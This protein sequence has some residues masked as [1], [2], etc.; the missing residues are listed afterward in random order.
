MF[1]D[2]KFEEIGKIIPGK[3]VIKFPGTDINML[4][5]ES[6]V[7]INEAGSTG[8]ASLGIRDVE[9]SEAG[10]VEGL[11]GMVGRQ[12]MDQL[13]DPDIRDQV[14]QMLAN[15]DHPFFYSKAED[16]TEIIS[17]IGMSGEYSVDSQSIEGVVV[18][19]YAT[20]GQIP[21][22]SQVYN[23]HMQAVG[24]RVL[25]SDRSALEKDVMQFVSKANSVYEKALEA[26]QESL[27]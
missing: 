14:K 8:Y 3:L 21:A 6:T 11:S 24:D 19:S 5:D 12:L 9:C 2:Q 23:H 25:A 22:A 17:L 20:H 13:S 4:Y 26:M 10:E 15:V 7:Y 27:F 1:E 18:A 16:G